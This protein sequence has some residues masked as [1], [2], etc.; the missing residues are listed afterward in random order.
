MINQHQF[1]YKGIIPASKSMMNRALIIQSYDPSIEI[2][3]SSVC[4]DVFYMQKAVDA[5]QK[6]ENVFL[7]G[8]AGTVFRFLALRL[9]RN[10]GSFLLQGSPR[11]LSRPQSELLR[12]L[13]QLGVRCELRAEALMIESSGWK[14]PIAPLIIDR[15]QSSQ[16]ASALLLNAW[17]L[18]FD[19][20][21]E[22]TGS[23]L[24][25]T[26]W[27]MT[28]EMLK[29]CGMQIQQD[30]G[31][32]KILAGQR[33]TA[34]KI[35][36]EP[37][38]SSAF[39]V[40][41]A[42]VLAGQVTFENWPFQS[43]QADQQFLEILADMGVKLEKTENELIIRKT[44]NLQKIE[45]NLV[46]C[47]DLFPVLCVLCS[48]AHG[49]SYLYGAPHLNA[50]ES[51]RIDK[52]SE[53]LKLM[54]VGH[55]PQKDGMII[56]GQGMTHDFKQ[57]TFDPDQDHRLAMAAGIAMMAGYNVNLLTPEVVSKSFPEYWSVLGSKRTEKDSL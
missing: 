42:A 8:E 36:L 33:L 24:S 45:F 40:A 50:K 57:F 21:F 17:N 28:V 22:F 38:M 37:D 23:L 26:Y 51:R 41:V 53:L 3:G 15:S 30:M 49:T 44:S 29:S 6:N 14:K 2:I 35:Q 56:Q 31:K 25:E 43:L 52:S 39:P 5:L 54:G 34:K 32:F 27:Q 4:D 9:A 13:E 16:F 48:F 10:T 55:S 11:L 47:P 46:D 7:S 18:D 19:L 1:Y 12:I 20:E